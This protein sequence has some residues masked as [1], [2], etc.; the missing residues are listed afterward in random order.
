MHAGLFI[1]L[2]LSVQ[3]A[4]LTGPPVVAKVNGVSVLRWE[5]ERELANRITVS[6][7]HKRVAPERLKEL[8]EET[9]EALILKELKRQWVA[10]K[11]VPVDPKAAESAWR[12]DRGRFPTQKSYEDSLK[13]QGL[14]HAAFRKVFD[15]DEAAAAADRAVRGTLPAP[16]DQDVRAYF[17]TH[18]SEYVKPEARR[19]VMA[20]VYVDPGGGELAR[21]AGQEKAEALAA[22]VRAGGSL[23]DEAQKLKPGLPPAYREGTGDL[24]FVHRGSVLPEMEKEIFEAQIPSLRG[25]LQSM[26]GYHVVQVLAAKPAE[27]LPLAA[28]RDAVTAQIAR[29]REKEALASFE[30]GLRKTARVERF[31]WAAGP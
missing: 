7:Y 15:R 1:A 30:A 9:R 14:T 12:K 17:A 3:A 5:A 29:E 22:R 23:A 20:L 6:S 16:T 27:P 25:P 13:E 2:S 4:A 31:E 21:K 11:R 18:G 26:Y 28:V 8:R 19:L 24:G 10:E